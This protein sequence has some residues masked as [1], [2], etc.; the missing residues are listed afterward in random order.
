VAGRRGRARLDDG[1]EHLAEVRSIVPQENVRTRTRPVRF[2]PKFGETSK[3]LAANQS[4]TVDVPVGE[5]SEV[6]TVHKDAVVYRGQDTVVYAVRNGRAFPVK[7]KLGDA[8]G[9]RFIVLSGLEAG[10]SVVTHGNETLPPGAE[11]R[12]FE[13]DAKAGSKAG[14]AE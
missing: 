4:V 13:G 11:I 10:D 8:V 9:S 12:L 7:A 2:A 3:P 14:N 1:T 5:I 6:V